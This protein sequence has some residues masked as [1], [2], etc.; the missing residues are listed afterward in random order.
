MKIEVVFTM[1]AGEVD[2]DVSKWGDMLQIKPTECFRLGDI[3]PRG[4]GHAIA[5]SYWSLTSKRL[6]DDSINR[7]VSLLTDKLKSKS[8]T[9]R[10]LIKQYKLECGIAAFVWLGDD[11]DISDLDLY[12]DSNTVLTLSE[13]QADFAIRVYE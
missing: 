9:I 6:E 4:K 8:S 11:E 12:L 7:Q 10:K 1:D 5:N 2:A 13:L 3:S